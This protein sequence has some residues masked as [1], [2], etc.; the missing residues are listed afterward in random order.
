ML[1]A[2]ILFFANAGR[3]HADAH[4]W[5]DHLTRKDVVTALGE[6]NSDAAGGNNEIMSYGGG[7]VIQLQ[8]GV[9]T[10]VSGTVPNA[11][12]TPGA[13]TTTAAG[14]ASGATVVTA[15]PAGTDNSTP[16]AAATTDASAPTAVEASPA[17]TNPT[18]QDSEKI[19]SDF[20]TKSI[21]IPGTPLSG[22]ITKALGPGEDGGAGNVSLLPKNLPD[23]SAAA[24][25]ASSNWAQPNNFKGFLIGLLIKSLVM[26]VVLKCVFAYKDFPLLWRD[27]ALVAAGVALSN[28]ILAYMFSMSDFG[29]I[30][31]L[32]QADQFVAGFVLLTLITTFT[33]AKSFPTAAGITITAMIA[34]TALSYA[35]YFFL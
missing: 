29:K 8:D 30:A 31:A 26:T 21:V 10:D 35:Q 17:A 32:V 13:R 2:A 4:A 25:G 16:S 15:V 34:N 18:D 27:A 12:K 28:Q 19:I 11:L 22:V 7:V 24:L 9:V 6:P 20:S 23:G 1:W 5:R 3:A 14:G 33:A